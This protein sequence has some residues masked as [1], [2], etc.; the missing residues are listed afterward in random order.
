LVRK[1]KMKIKEIFNKILWDP[2]EKERKG[3]YEVTFIHRGA[4]KDQEIIPLTMIKE[5]KSS[6][7]IYTNEYGEE[8]YIPFHRI[9]E[10]RNRKTGEVLWS[11]RM[12][13][14]NEPVYED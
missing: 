4:Y 6:M 11:K 3:D 8:T 1:R 7:F 13:E 14:S 5:V 2:R 9:I 10:I 12:R